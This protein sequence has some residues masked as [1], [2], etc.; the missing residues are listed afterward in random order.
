M[1]ADNIGAFSSGR[2]RGRFP[3]RR[4]IGHVLDDRPRNVASGRASAWIDTNRSARCERRGLRVPAADDIA[5]SCQDR[6]KAAGRGSSATSSIDRGGR[7]PFRKT[8]TG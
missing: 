7:R 8:R 3:V 5:T 1:P 2:Q 4:L 6:P